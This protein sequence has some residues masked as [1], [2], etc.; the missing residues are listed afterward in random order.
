LSWQLCFLY[1][2]KEYK[3]KKKETEGEE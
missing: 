3:I 1:L 2:L